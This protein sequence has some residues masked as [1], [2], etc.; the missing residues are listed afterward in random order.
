MATVTKDGHPV[1]AATWFLLEPDGRV[2][3]NL[4]AGRRRLSHLRRDPRFA[5][6][7]MDGADWY[8]HVALQLEVSDIT[9]DNGLAD[10]DALS[11]HY[12]GTAYPNRDRP[13]VTA[14]AEITKWMGWGVDGAQ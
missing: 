10:I 4:D 6:D 8:S 11:R 13:R 3:I 12:L 2:M 1:T 14:R 9:D 7:V 5:L